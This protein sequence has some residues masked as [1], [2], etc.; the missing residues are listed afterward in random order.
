MKHYVWKSFIVIAAFFIG[1][2]INHSCGKSPIDDGSAPST[3]E[4]W[5]SVR[6]LTSEMTA[7]KDENAKLKEEVARLS[8]KI[9]Q[10]ENSGSLSDGSGGID[11]GEKLIDGLYFNRSGMVSSKIKFQNIRE[12]I[13]YLYDSQG[14]F[15]GY[16]P[17]T[18]NGV[19]TTTSI[20]YS[21]KTVTHTQTS[22]YEP[23]LYPNQ[24]EER[25]TQ[26]T[27]EYY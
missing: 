15:I 26:Y 4:L 10:L 16:P 11:S 3:Q 22:T 6:S 19:T 18:V 24:P 25:V 7:L 14:R 27:I 1:V 8:E 21:G 13:E 9:E 23:E 20:T 17:Q 12:N 2:T 5:N